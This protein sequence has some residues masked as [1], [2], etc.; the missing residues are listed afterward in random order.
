M[1]RP[2]KKRR[3]ATYADLLAAPK[4][5]LSELIDGTLYMSPRP[6]SRHALAAG[7]VFAPLH[8]RF[9]RSGGGPDVWVILMEPELHILGQVM[10]PDIAGWRR[11]RMPETP[12]VAAFEL[13]PDWVCE[14]VSSSTGAL[15]RKHK[16]PH[17]ARAGVEHAWLID[18]IAQ[19]LEVFR[20]DGPEWRL[21]VT[22]AEDD[23]VHVPPFEP[24]ELSL[25]TPWAR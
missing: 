21:V 10:V 9:H 6:A 20:L 7:G 12:D 4:H 23:V 25:A 5:V 8:G 22:H 1:S 18:P 2:I 13:A 17:Y 11:T 15:D 3:P 19:T 24:L 16:M 14:V